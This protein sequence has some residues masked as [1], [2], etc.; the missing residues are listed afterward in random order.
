MKI[1]SVWLFKRIAAGIDA[2]IPSG[3]PKKQFS[4][5]IPKELPKELL[6]KFQLSF[7]FRLWQLYKRFHQEFLRKIPQGI[8]TVISLR[9]SFIEFVPKFFP[10]ILPGVHHLGI[11]LSIPGVDSLRN[12][13]WESLQKPPK[14]YSGNLLEISAGDSYSESFSRKSL[15]NFFSICGF[16]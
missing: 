16:I 14:F 2:D 4:N 15:P 12:F 13:L 8:S 1:T 3:I 10:R 11:P 9:K 5:Y 6:N 7:I